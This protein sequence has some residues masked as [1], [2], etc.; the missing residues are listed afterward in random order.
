MPGSADLA[1]DAAE[2]HLPDAANLHALAQSLLGLLDHTQMR[3]ATAESCTGGFLASVLTDIEGLSHCVDRGF[4]TYSKAAKT[5]M[6]GIDVEMIETEG[7]VSE[8]VARAMAENCLKRAES[9]LA[10]AITGLAGSP[11]P[12]EREGTGVIYVAAAIADQSWVY[13]VDYGERTRREV[14][15]LA[16]AA[17]LSIGMRAV[18]IA[19]AR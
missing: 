17:A 16:T 12:D 9:D 8:G 2:G 3:V 6:L 1:H 10:L 14:R 18:A 11:D 7:A 15:N 19:D 13:R 4:V 5:D